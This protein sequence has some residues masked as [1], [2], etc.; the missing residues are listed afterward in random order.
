M[1]RLQRLLLIILA[2]LMLNQ[3]FTQGAAPAAKSF[4]GALAVQLWS[5]RNDFK[6]DVPGTLKRVHDLGFTNVELAGFYGMTAKQFR[7]ELDKA[8]LKA[9]SMHVGYDVLRDRLDSIIADAKVLG[10][11]AVGVA[12][13]KSPF[14]R[15]DCLDAIN[16][17]NQAGSKLA[18]HGLKFFYHLHGY[19]F[20]PDEGGQGTLFDLLMTKTDPRFVSIQL[21]TA[22]VAFPGQDPAQ[23]MRKYPG[24][25]TSLHMKDVR[26]D[27]PGNNSGVFKDED[28]R[29]LGQGKINWP[30][31]LKVASQQHVRWYIVEDETPVVWQTIPETLRYLESVKF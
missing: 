11:E 22:H 27:I 31:T 16:V 28:G 7:A 17:F 6:K 10:V 1:N 4:K 18:A 13:I 14:T 29:P 9:I 8:G 23:L 2:G 3:P 20:V 21:D 26:A 25:F 5:F 12:W 19:E 24:R 30:D 15:K